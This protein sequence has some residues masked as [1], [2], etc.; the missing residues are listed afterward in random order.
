[1]VIVVGSI[2]GCAGGAHEAQ[3][4][5][6]PC[7]TSTTG[8]TATTI[9][10]D[11]ADAETAARIR[12]ASELDRRVNELSVRWMTADDNLVGLIVSAPPLLVVE[13]HYAA[14]T[15]PAPFADDLSS[16]GV[17]V[18]AV[19]EP[20]GRVRYRELRQEIFDLH[21]R[22]LRGAGEK[23]NPF[24]RLAS[25]GTDVV[26]MGFD[27]RRVRLVFIVRDCTDVEATRRRVARALQDGDIDLP[28]ATV[29]IHPSDPMN[30]TATTA[31]G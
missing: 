11:R 25:S 22:Y 3:T 27:D 29:D 8:V 28:D 1:L 17:S 12:A 13:V 23:D 9:D 20:F 26:A 16:L 31:N 2:T 24:V 30:P 14:A 4:S 10:P 6:A 7:P 21:E 5:A 18:E 15:L 19:T